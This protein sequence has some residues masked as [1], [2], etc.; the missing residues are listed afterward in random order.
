MSVEHLECEVLRAKA[1]GAVPFMVV[2]T[3]GTT[4][5][6]AFDPIEQIADVCKKHDLWLHI[7]AAWGGGV[8]LSQK[9]RHLVKGIERSVSVM[10]CILRCLLFLLFVFV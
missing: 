4:V 5:L 7:D 1:E 8:M 6:G 2:A 9:Y 10:K 3:A